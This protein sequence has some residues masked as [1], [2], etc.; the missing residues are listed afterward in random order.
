MSVLFV[1]DHRFVLDREGR[2]YSTGQYSADIMARYESAFGDVHIAGRSQPITEALAG[3]LN[4][5]Q[6]D[7]SRF[8]SIPD[9]SSLRSLLIKD[10]EAVAR[11]TRTIKSVDVVVA[12][13]PS[14]IGLMAI[15]IAR[16]QGKPVI[17][18]VVACVWDGLLSHGS[19]TALL[20][21]PIAYARMR[22]AVSRSNRTIYVTKY[23]LQKRYPN[24]G[25]QAN[26]SN[27]QIAPPDPA[28]LDRRLATIAGDKSGLTFGMI[29]AM[30]H[31]EK[32]VDIAIKALA[33]AIQSRPDLEL[34]LEVVGAGDTSSLRKMAEE[35]GVG[36]RV[37][38]LG[39]LPHGEK[40]FSWIDSVDAYIQTSFQEGLPR[41]LIETMSRAT[42]ALASSA[43]GTAELIRHECLHK[44][45]D[46]VTL[47]RQMIAATNAEWR[48]AMAKAN[49]E[50]SKAYASDIL[51][52]RRKA[53]WASI[54]DRA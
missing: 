20:Y 8:V 49:F 28:I 23:F 33:L 18:E 48:E 34:K 25:R 38:F 17:V 45:G 5:I 54:A 4:L 21:A 6:P 26:I 32:R 50:K 42:P 7:T 22:K 31:N 24:S 10:H 2:V 53:F 3:R 19:L 46:A 51:N 36:D 30:F 44:P 29:A 15:D 9:L 47:S 13:L 39:V 1:H 16:Q 43:G 40:L 37:K 41:A 11:L 52:A 35:L 27:V 12:R 14:E